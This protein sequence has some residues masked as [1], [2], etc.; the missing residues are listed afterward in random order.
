M[1]L[2]ELSE[3]LGVT[4][5]NGSTTT[6]DIAR[7]PR[8]E[9]K[10]LSFLSD[11]CYLS[12]P[13]Y[14]S[15]SESEPESESSFG[16]EEEEE[17]LRCRTTPSPS[18]PHSSPASCHMIPPPPHHS[19]APVSYIT[20]PNSPHQLLPS[21]S[22]SLVRHSSLNRCDV[23]SNSGLSEKIDKVHVSCPDFHSRSTDMELGSVSQDEECEMDTCESHS[24]KTLIAGGHTPR[25]FWGATGGLDFNLPSLGEPELSRLTP[26]EPLKSTTPHFV[27]RG[28]K[29]SPAGGSTRQANSPQSPWERN[30]TQPPGP[31][32]SHLRIG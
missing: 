27:D 8:I 20:A 5:S 24:S 6:P 28:G 31:P 1:S 19:P 11:S 17:L 21:S 9:D 18:P 4:P 23:L 13:L 14:F 3:C 2:D 22:S 16:E 12:S 30:F 7:R 26:L 10:L 25:E 32:S 29:K 15:G